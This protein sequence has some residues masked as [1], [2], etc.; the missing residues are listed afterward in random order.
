MSKKILLITLL[1]VFLVSGCGTDLVKAKTDYS[2]FIELCKESGESI[3]CRITQ[4][5]A[6]A[7]DLYASALEARKTNLINQA[8]F[9][10]VH[11]SVKE[12]RSTL[13]KAEVAADVVE[14]AK[15][16]DQVDNLFSTLKTL[17]TSFGV[18]LL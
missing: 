7:G 2:D 9:Y 3:D 4:G 6:Y 18:G 13:E 17:L 14:A 10:K 15:N 12:I 16:L 11:T 8:Q 1:S 5:Y